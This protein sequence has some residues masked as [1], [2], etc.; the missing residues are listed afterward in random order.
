MKRFRSERYGFEI[1]LPSGWSC[2]WSGLWGRLL[3]LDRDLKFKSL[4]GFFNVEVGSNPFD[5]INDAIKPITYGDLGVC[6]KDHQWMRYMIGGDAA[7]R[8]PASR[9]IISSMR[10]AYRDVVGFMSDAEYLSEMG[11]G[12]NP[13][14]PVLKTYCLAFDGKIF[15]FTASL[16]FGTL[17]E[18]SEEFKDRESMYDSIVSSFK[19][20]EPTTSD[21]SGVGSTPFDTTREYDAFISYRSSNANF[22]RVIADQLIAVG[23][24]PWFAEYMILLQGRQDFQTRID[25]GLARSKYGLIFFSPGYTASMYC[26]HELKVLKSTLPV[27]RVLAMRLVGMKPDEFDPIERNLETCSVSEVLRF[28][29]EEMGWS[30]K[31]CDRPPRPEQSHRATC[32]GIPYSLDLAEWR[33]IKNGDLVAPHNPEQGITAVYPAPKGPLGMNLP[34]SSGAAA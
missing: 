2:P 28:V 34:R 4:E 11:Q 14:G 31:P 19:L 15:S 33:D 21:A 5:L 17:A 23:L 26:M 7:L 30:M 27:E 8:I 22:A 16:G 6:G 20:L 9:R 24:N 18:V 25:A 12:P 3:G 13:M 10:S 1:E 29:A 32:F